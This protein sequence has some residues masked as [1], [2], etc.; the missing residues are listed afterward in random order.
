MIYNRG[1]LRHACLEQKFEGG[2]VNYR[3]GLSFIK[4]DRPSGGENLFTKRFFPTP[5]SK[6]FHNRGF[7]R[8]ACL[9]RKFEG[10]AVN[11]RQGLSFIN[12]TAL[13]NCRAFN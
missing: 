2:A 9:E 10:G 6:K 12:T 5:L 3:R 13:N 1:F 4:R 7:L 8:H 11:Y